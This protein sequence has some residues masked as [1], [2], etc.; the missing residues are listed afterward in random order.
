MV[1]RLLA[2]TTLKVRIQTSD[3]NQQMNNSKYMANTSYKKSKKELP[4]IIFT[5]EPLKKLT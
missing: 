2:K 4:R 3:N 1:A 5:T